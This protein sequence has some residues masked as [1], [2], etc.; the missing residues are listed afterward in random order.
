MVDLILK[1][2]VIFAG[3]TDFISLLPVQSPHYAEP[4]FRPL[5][6]ALVHIGSGRLSLFPTV[7]RLIEYQLLLGNNH[8]AHLLE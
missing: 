4:Q 2:R 3:L 8:A 5:A 1:T 7:G 6:K